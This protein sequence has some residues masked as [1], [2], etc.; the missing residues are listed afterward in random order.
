MNDVAFAQAGLAV[1]EAKIIFKAQPPVSDA[2]IARIEDGLA[3]PVPADLV[4]LWKICYGGRIDYDLDVC[5]GAHIHKFSFG[6]LF[7]PRSGSYHD[8]DGWMAHERDLIVENDTSTNHDSSLPLEF[9][10]FGGFEYLERLYVRV[11]SHDYGA[12]YA[13]AQGIPPDWSLNL[14][15]NSSARVADSVRALFQLLYLARNPFT[16]S[17][18][19]F[20]TGLDAIEA[21]E[22]ARSAGTLGG[23]D[24]SSLHAMLTAAIADWRSGLDR[25]TLSGNPRL[26]RLAL[27]HVAETGDVAL[28]QRLEQQGVDLA[29]PL[30]GGGGLLDHALIHGHV[31]LAQALLDRGLKA[32]EQT[33]QCAPDN[34]EPALLLRLHQAG[35]AP[36]QYAVL[37][38]ARAGRFETAELL[39]QWLCE[40]DPAARDLLRDRCEQGAVSNEQS[41]KR[42][43]L[44]QM[45]SDRTPAFYREEARRLRHFAAWL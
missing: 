10:P 14:H 2:E 18:D 13:Y 12:I 4:A 34:A 39:A 5:F 30:T 8:L 37:K 35:A 22:Q 28:L 40:Q 17:P 33:L 44:G 24:A 16:A 41:A 31:G 25:G 6:E 23:S 45:G 1:F 32:G 11:G 38:A 20:P 3:G 42:I 36:N 9:L 43:E 26:A 19:T 29:S 21:I 15:E 7:Y 27:A